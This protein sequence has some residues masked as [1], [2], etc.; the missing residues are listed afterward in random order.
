[1]VT[2]K[3]PSWSQKK[4]LLGAI[5]GIRERLDALDQKLIRGVP[6]TDSEHAFYNDVTELHEK[7]TTV[8]RELLHQVEIVGNVT[9]LEKDQALAAQ[10]R[11]D[12]V[13]CQGKRPNNNRQ[14]IAAQGAFG[15]T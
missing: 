9:A 12:C 8:R 6:L 14:G 3:C 11:E 5:E 7:E 13:A 2:N 4:G 10:F 1:M 15:S